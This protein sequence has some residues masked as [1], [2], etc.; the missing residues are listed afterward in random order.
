MKIHLAA[1]AVALAV[2]ACGSTQQRV[3]PVGK[4][5]AK[6]I[7]VVGNPNARQTFLTTYQQALE[8]KGFTVAMIGDRSA[9][10]C[11][12]VSTY[13]ARWSWSGVTM[14]MTY[15]DIQVWQD[16]QPVGRASYDAMSRRSLDKI[17]NAES[18]I[19]ELVDQLFPNR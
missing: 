1:A 15:A 19:V 3:V 9:P 12:L 8:S 18:K 6:R 7:C 17:I 5:E 10:D 14:S 11:P 16:G 4:I 13:N 2:A